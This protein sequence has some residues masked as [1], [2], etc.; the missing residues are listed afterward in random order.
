MGAA[1]QERR[2]YNS[3]YLYT[4]EAK[5]VNRL[6]SE[7]AHLRYNW[8]REGL[9][10]NWFDLPNTG[11]M[12]NT[13]LNF[14]S[15]DLQEAG[16]DIGKR[17]KV[18]KSWLEKTETDLRSFILEYLAGRLVFPIYYTI[19]NVNGSF[20]IINTLHG[21]GKK[22]EDT[23]SKKERNGAVWDTFVNHVEP[24]LLKARD[25]SIA[26]VDSPS[27]PS[28]FFDEAGNPIDYPDSQTYILQKRGSEI[29][30]FAIKTD[31][32]FSEHK[33][34]LARLRR[35]AGQSEPQIDK[36]EDYITN[37]AL[38]DSA[39][40]PLKIEDIL[41][42]MQDVRLKSTGG[43]L[44][45]FENKL[46]REVYA[47]IRRGDDLWRYDSLT[48][49][50]IDDFKDYFLGSTKTYQDVKEALAA[51]ILRI[52]RFVRGKLKQ[53]SALSFGIR[54]YG[55]ER[56]SLYGAVL[57]DLQNIAGCAGGGSKRSLFD[58]LV[59]RFGEISKLSSDSEEK[60]CVLCGEK[61]EELGP[62]GVCL[63]CEGK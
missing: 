6:P 3:E 11:F 16:Q 21:Q 18:N 26:V 25:G 2:N 29:V 17:E 32:T 44:C 58:S 35:Y 55:L 7:M 61:N 51:T 50:Y 53:N 28:G 23:I 12:I 1:L 13:Q 56:Y 33:E 43:S 37:L 9:A 57:K 4:Q 36:L 27:G 8:E 24:F 47:D 10:R 20:R 30:G 22:L 34:L 54:D 63:P 49:E 14:L 59:P 62:C 19:E 5:R 60:S 41:N 31:F 40:M 45:A 52:S 39:N 42:V 46:W 15:Q 38:F 48:D